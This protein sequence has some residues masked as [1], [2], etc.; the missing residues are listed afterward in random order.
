MGRRS[1]RAG[2]IT[3]LQRLRAGA[4][5]SGSDTGLQQAAITL[6]STPTF[7]DSW[8]Q[9]DGWT[10]AGAQYLTQLDNFPDQYIPSLQFENLDAPSKFL[11]PA[12]AQIGKNGGICLRFYLYE[13]NK[14]GD[15]RDVWAA[16]WAQWRFEVTGGQARLLRKSDEWTEALETQ[17][18][19]LLDLETPDGAQQT[20]IDT[21]RAQ[22]YADS[23]SVELGK[24]DTYDTWHTITFLPEARGFVN[25]LLP[26]VAESQSFE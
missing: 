7:P 3:N 5:K 16:T 22:I 13:S 1:K 15:G 6:N 12:V 14:D 21:L 4:G 9:K 20:Q 25:V 18:L 17:L 2:A 23:H 11:S 24:G 8:N 26:G 10:G 19:D